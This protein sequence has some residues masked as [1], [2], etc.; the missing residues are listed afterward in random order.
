MIRDAT[1]L[2]IGIV[3]GINVMGFIRVYREERAR[4][5]LLGGQND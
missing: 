4:R 1:L 2:F 5:R 3:V